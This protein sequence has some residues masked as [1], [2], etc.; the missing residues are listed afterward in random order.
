MRVAMKGVA[1]TLLAPLPGILLHMGEHTR[2]LAV[3]E[4]TLGQGQAR[5][6]GHYLTELHRLRSV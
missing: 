3:V 6:D 4:E 5:K 1:E 2:A